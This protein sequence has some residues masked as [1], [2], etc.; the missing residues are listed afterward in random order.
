MPF[1][2]WKTKGEDEE[3]EK[4]GSE[5]GWMEQREN[6]GSSVRNLP[7][8]EN[9]HDKI[10]RLNLLDRKEWRVAHTNASGSSETTQ[11]QREERG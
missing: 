7:G 6:G 1:T 3:G 5:K 10:R 2:P 4:E 11:R 8:K 9:G